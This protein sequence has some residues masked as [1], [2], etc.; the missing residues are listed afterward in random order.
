MENITHAND[1]A[2]IWFMVVFGACLLTQVVD[3]GRR[4]WK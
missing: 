2:A 3:F 1:V 4:C